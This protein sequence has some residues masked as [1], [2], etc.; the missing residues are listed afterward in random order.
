M[1]TRSEEVGG[2]LRAMMPWIEKKQLVD[3]A[4]NWDWLPLFDQGGVSCAPLIVGVPEGLCVRCERKR[5]QI[6]RQFF[7]LHA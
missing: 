6:L 5:T 4:R 2:K 3:K 1:L 7:V